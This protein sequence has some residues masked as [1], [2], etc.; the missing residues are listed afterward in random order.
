LYSAPR[1]YNGFVP[2]PLSVV[3]SSLVKIHRSLHRQ[4]LENIVKCPI[5]VTD[6][7]NAVACKCSIENG[8]SD[9]CCFRGVILSPYICS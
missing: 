2:L 6:F 9:I 1:K 7:Q 5:S 8:I 3:S 4:M